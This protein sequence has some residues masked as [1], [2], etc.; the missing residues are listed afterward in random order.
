MLYLLASGLASAGSPVLLVL[1]DSL[2]AAYN[3]GQDRG[4]VSL[5]QR[6]LARD[7][8]PHRVVNASISGET[9]G[10][11]LARLPRLL[12][13]H[14]PA[15]VVI[16]LGANDGLRALSAKVLGDNLRA[17]ITASRAAGARVLLLG[18]RLPPNYGAA[19]NA[20]FEKVYAEV[21]AEAGVALEPFFL[22]GIAERRELML[23]DG[24]HPAAE[25]QPM[26]L[27]NV[28]PTLAPLLDATRGGVN[29]SAPTS[30]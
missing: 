15:V 21:A 9:S 12:E 10:G 19:F 7:G 22:R 6:R 14:R 30:G 16:E 5:M 28:W 24:L 29:G 23:P 20:R 17:M 27:D 2:S 1:G 11:G 8:Y 3:I 25:A 18:I 13:E 26:L 4:W